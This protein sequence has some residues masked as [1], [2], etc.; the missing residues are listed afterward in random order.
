MPI[1]LDLRVVLMAGDNV[2][3]ESDDADLWQQVLRSLYGGQQGE[4]T[5]SKR[6]GHLNVHD[7]PSAVGTDSAIASFAKAID[8]SPE[9]IVGALSPEMDAPYLTLDHHCWESFKRGTPARGRGAVGATAVVGTLLAFWTQRIKVADVRFSTV[10]KV[11][12][13]VGTHD[14][15]PRRTIRNCPWLRLVGGRIRLNPAKTSDAE[16]LVRAFV[17]GDWSAYRRVQVTDRKEA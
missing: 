8:V 12:E 10:A 11:L 3:A 1:K 2:V 15:L 4:N 7:E 17:V 9:D 14:A 13:N 6:A 5:L 16:R